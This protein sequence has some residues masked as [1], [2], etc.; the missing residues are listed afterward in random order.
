MVAITL[1]STSSRFGAPL[2]VN[3]KSPEK[4]SEKGSEFSEK[5]KAKKDWIRTAEST[6]CGG[7]FDEENHEAGEDESGCDDTQHCRCGGEFDEENHARPQFRSRV[8]EEARE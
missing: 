8:A 5:G 4:T 7:E 6:I 2:D 3:V 1:P